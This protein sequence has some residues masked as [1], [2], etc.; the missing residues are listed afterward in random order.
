MGR[1]LGCAAAP[2]Q[3]DR[4]PISPRGGPG[5][6]SPRGFT[7]VEILVVLVILAVAGGLAVVTLD[8]DDRG[9]ASREAKR[10]AGALEYAAQRA[11]WR[12]ETIG[13][14]AEGPEIRF[15]RREPSGERWQPIVDD[16]VLAP[17]RLPERFAAG[18]VVYAGQPVA[19][20]AVVPL[21][22]TG[23]NEPYVFELASPEWHIL[24]ASD[25]LNRVAI[26]G[27]SYGSR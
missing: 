24:L 18:A 2:L 5:H 22:P 3:P 10:F 16:D 25:P 12:N 26:D 17:R 11:Q 15:W 8:R 9:T 23:R 14:T 20:N 21:R 19:S 13:V 6:P 1:N 4:P 7:L 27:P